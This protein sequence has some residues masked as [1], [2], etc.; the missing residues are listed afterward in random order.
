VK[1]RRCAR[2]RRTARLAAAVAAGLLLLLSSQPG[3]A[4][5][6]PQPLA[7]GKDA[8]LFETVDIEGK[9]FALK[10]AI[11]AGPVMLVFWSVFCGSCR[12]ELPILQQE[13]PKFEER[14]IRLIAVNLDVAAQRK[15]V[16]NFAKK[17]GF[18]FVM[19]LNEDD[20]KTYDIDKLYDVKMTPALYLIGKDGKVV[21]S[22]YG[23]LNPEELE[24]VLTKV[25]A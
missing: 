23:P 17:E 3:R 20:T 10:E 22:H 24:E 13:F 8:P 7:A 2:F 11:A 4:E 5:G 12:D 1:T 9:P 25:P 16:K 19:A 15:A 18:S 14:K 6:G 21:F